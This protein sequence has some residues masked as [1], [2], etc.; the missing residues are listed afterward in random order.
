[1][2]WELAAVQVLR[3]LEPALHLQ[4]ELPRVQQALL[5]LLLEQDYLLLPLRIY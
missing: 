1:M 2:L 3:V 5:E 4:Q